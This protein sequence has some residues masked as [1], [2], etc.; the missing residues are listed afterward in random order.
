MW[1]ENT[2]KGMLIPTHIAIAIFF[3]IKS[4]KHSVHYCATR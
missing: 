3:V 2:S 1:S 4:C